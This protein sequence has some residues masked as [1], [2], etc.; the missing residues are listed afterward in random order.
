MQ[1]SIQICPAEKAQAPP[2]AA[3]EPP[4]AWNVQ[5]TNLVEPAIA[6]NAPPYPKWLALP[7]K[8][9]SWINIADSMALIPPLPITPL[10]AWFNALLLKN[11]EFRTLMLDCSALIAPTLDGPAGEF[12]APPFP[13]NSKR[14]PVKVLSRSQ[15]AVPDVDRSS[16]FHIS[17]SERVAC[18][19]PVDAAGGGPFSMTRPSR[20]TE[21]FETCTQAATPPPEIVGTPTPRSTIDLP[22]TVA[23]APD[24]AE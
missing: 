22:T 15:T 9:H 8:M 4:F 12:S 6:A 3:N 1:P 24:S 17:T 13:W 23:T 16:Q 18:T 19:A 10:S 7:S 20:C 2:P 11:M 21:P 14:T 5:S